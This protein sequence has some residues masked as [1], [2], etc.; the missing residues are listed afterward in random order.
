MGFSCLPSL[1]PHSALV[2]PH[3][4]YCVQAYSPQYRKDVGAEENHKDDA[5]TGEPLL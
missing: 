2:R 5:R 1:P 3:L 4:E